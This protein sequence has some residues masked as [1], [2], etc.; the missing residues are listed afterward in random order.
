MDGWQIL[1]P[2]EI[3]K[4]ADN[5]CN[6]HTIL[7]YSVIKQHA[8][9]KPV[10]WHKSHPSINR[11]M[12]CLNWEK[13]ETN[14][15]RVIRA[16]KKLNE[17]GI[18]NYKRGTSLGR[19]SNTYT[20]RLYRTTRRWKGPSIKGTT[21][22]PFDNNKTSQ[23]PP[24]DTS[25][26]KGD[27]PS[28]NEVTN[29]SLQSIKGNLQKNNISNE[30]EENIETQDTESLETREIGIYGTWTGKGQEWCL[31]W[32]CQ[33]L[34]ETPSMVMTA[35]NRTERRGIHSKIIG[36]IHQIPESEPVPE[37]LEKAIQILD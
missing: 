21:L 2:E 25:V 20:L 35:F 12:D 4:L 9:A 8:Y 29:E 34:I 13:T 22:S 16:V 23:S 36:T 10:G 24:G 30:N 15:R 7:V 1:Y 32:L 26:G 31:L 17:I 11:I 19:V 6:G 37:E 5:D 14:K 27:S 3:R 28:K 18:L 33:H